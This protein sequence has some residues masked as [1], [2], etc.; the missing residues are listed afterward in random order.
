MFR[1]Q[2][3]FISPR[4]G[5]GRVCAVAISFPLSLM[6]SSI[7]VAQVVYGNGPSSPYNS[8]QFAPGSERYTLQTEVGC[9]TPSFNVSAFAGRANDWANNLT[10]YA[11][12]NSGVGNYGVALGF[13]T[14]LSNDLSDFCSNYAALRTTYERQRVETQLL[15]SQLE[16]FKQCR[17]FV[18]NGYN[19]DDP[20]FRE[21][22]AL[23]SIGQCKSLAKILTEP[24]KPN[25]I[26]GPP[27]DEPEQPTCKSE[28][29]TSDQSKQ[30]TCKPKQPASVPSFTPAPT[31][32]FPVR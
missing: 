16:L 1:T 9:P 23:S 4:W 14:P 3:S 13:S 15:T 25:L 6:F 32:V 7:T 26:P 22:G 21:E 18:D 30:S 20:V 24:R 2:F 17:W 8:P 5:A 19:L 29:S 27:V 10:P 31:T 11:S 12:S 28:Q